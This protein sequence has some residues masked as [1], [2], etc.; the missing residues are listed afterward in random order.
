MDNKFRIKCFATGRNIQHLTH[1]TNIKNI[2]TI[3]QYGLLTRKY[4]NDNKISYIY[5]DAYRYDDLE[6]S[7]S[8]SVTFPN[9]KM[10]YKLRMDN[11][12]ERW[13]VLV[14]KALPILELDCVFCRTNAANDEMREIPVCERKRFSAFQD[15]FYERNDISRAGLRLP[16]NFTTDPQA[17]ILV[18]HNIPS[19]WIEKI[20]VEKDEDIILINKGA[21][22]ICT[23]RDFFLPRVDYEKW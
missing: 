22:N 9:Y 8:V 20:C 13:A 17:E 12:Y 19:D 2:D 10:F 11:P 16:D 1:F 23:D 5:N 18:C 3:M 14:L 6:D 4:M 15:M 21:I 7:I